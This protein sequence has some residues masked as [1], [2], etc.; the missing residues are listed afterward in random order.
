MFFLKNRNS[1]KETFIVDIIKPKS[2]QFWS[3]LSQNRKVIDGIFLTVYLKNQQFN[4]YK[5]I[6]LQF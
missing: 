5:C 6:K 4:N 3:Q 1:G 2:G